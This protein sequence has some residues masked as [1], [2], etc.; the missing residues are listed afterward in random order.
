MKKILLSFALLAGFA[1]AAET[2]T[3]DF[4]TA[5]TWF[6]T[7]N[8]KDCVADVKTATSTA[9]N[10]A[11]SYVFT[12]ASEGNGVI[13]QGTDNTG[14]AGYGGYLTFSLGIDCAQITLKTGAQASTAAVVNVYAGETL[15]KENLALNAQGTDFVIEVPAASQAAGTVYKI[16]NVG[17]KNAQFQSMTCASEATE[18]VDPVDPVE[19]TTVKFVK[20]NTIDNGKYIFVIDNKI[21]VPVAE[22]KN[23]GYMYFDVDAVMDGDDIVYNEADAMTVTVTDEKITLMDKYNRYYGMDDSHFTTFQL[24]NELNDG[25]YWTATYV[26]G[27]VQL[28]N[29][30]NSDRFIAQFNGGTSFYNNIAPGPKDVSATNEYNLPTIYKMADS[31]GVDAIETEAADADAPVVYYNLQGQR[32]AE[33]ENGLYIRVQGNKVEKVVIR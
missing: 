12:Y 1:A 25:C 15:I 2:V 19:P 20:A 16:D 21:A 11:Y 27:K 28:F 22:N 32:V 9:T 7:T 17:K 26:N 8:K 30:L 14:N 3:E 29:V 10:I 4:K 33:P 18:P 31:A 13:L 6:G 23:Y 5:N 24:Y